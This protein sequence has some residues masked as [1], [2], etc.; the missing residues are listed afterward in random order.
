[1][2]TTPF[3]VAVSLSVALGFIGLPDTK[4]GVDTRIGAANILSVNS[5]APPSWSRLPKICRRYSR[6]VGVA[7][8]GNYA[9]EHDGVGSSRSQQAQVVQMLAAARR[10]S[11]SR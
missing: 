7:F 11:T 3:S 5:E 1:M 10:V 9:D 8:R 6:Y 4:Q 2:K